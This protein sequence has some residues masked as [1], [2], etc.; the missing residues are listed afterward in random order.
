MK[1]ASYLEYNWFDSINTYIFF[2]SD[3]ILPGRREVKRAV[4]VPVKTPQAVNHIGDTEYNFWTPCLKQG[5]Y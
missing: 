4:I 3:R 1:L 2:L 5:K